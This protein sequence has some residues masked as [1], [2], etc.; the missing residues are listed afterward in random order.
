[1]VRPSQVWSQD[2]GEACVCICVFMFASACECVYVASMCGCG[3]EN[4]LHV[5][6][7]T[8]DFALHW[9]FTVL[10]VALQRGE[11]NIS[12]HVIQASLYS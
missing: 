3:H 12:S 10:A 6:S 5:D 8:T 2:Q 9:Q 4:G 1:M 7:R 11:Q